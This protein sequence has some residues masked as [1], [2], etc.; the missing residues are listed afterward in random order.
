M[1]LQQRRRL[2]SS[3][4][5]VVATGEEDLLGRYLIQIDEDGQHWW[6]EAD[7]YDGYSVCE[8]SWDHVQSHPQYLQRKKANHV[9]YLWDQLIELVASNSYAGTLMDYGMTDLASN[10][11]LLRIMASEPR[12]SR[13][14]NAVSFLQ[15]LETAPMSKRSARVLK[16][17]QFADRAYVF[18]ALPRRDGITEEEY[19]KVRCFLLYA[20]CLVLGARNRELRE[21]VGIGT[22]PGIDNEGRSTDFAA[23]VPSEWTDELLREAAQLQKDHKILAQKTLPWQHQ[24]SQEYPDETTDVH[25]VSLHS[26]RRTRRNQRRKGQ[27]ARGKRGRNDL[28]PCGSLKK[29]KKCCGKSS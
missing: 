12:L 15:F 18:V 2:F 20:Y 26:G 7:G 3:K 11:R 29:Y 27:A 5:V 13:R 1:Y 19:R 10:E 24:H 28:C 22:E 6:R 17:A 23:F 8:G 21:I 9:S 25:G 16:S 4:S 14:I